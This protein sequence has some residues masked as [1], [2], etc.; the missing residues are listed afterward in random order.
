[1]SPIIGLGGSCH[2]C[3]EGI[4]GSVIGVEKVRQGWISAAAPHNSFSEAILFEFDPQRISLPNLIAI[5]LHSHSCTSAHCMRKK[6]RSAIY[7]FS[8][9]QELSCLQALKN[10]QAE[11]D[12][13]IITE[14]LY[15]KDFRL[16]S[17]EYRDYYHN[18]PEKPFCQ[19]FIEPKLNRL[20]EKYSSSFKRKRT[21]QLDSSSIYQRP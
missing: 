18:N 16:N 2:W 13:K 8:A 9:D 5:H 3:T 11:F 4:F 15:F 1:M 10:L 19:K 17:E 14:V 12:E 20:L 6:Y 21:A 7:V